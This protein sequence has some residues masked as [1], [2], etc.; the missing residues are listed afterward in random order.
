MFLILSSRL[1]DKVYNAIYLNLM[2]SSVLVS[3]IHKMFRTSWTAISFLSCTNKEVHVC[4]D[5]LCSVY[6]IVC[7]LVGTW[8]AIL[9]TAQTLP[10]ACTL[11]RCLKASNEQLKCRTACQR[12]SSPAFLGGPMLQTWLGGEQ[13]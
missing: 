3:S 8:L 11:Q 5:G 10:E 1:S 12:Y 4:S 6:F 2:Q 9:S 7:L 13:K